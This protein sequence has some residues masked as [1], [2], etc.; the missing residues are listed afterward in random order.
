MRLCL[1]GEGVLAHTQL[2][3]LR[4]LSPPKTHSGEI[5]VPLASHAQAELVPSL[6]ELG[7]LTQLSNTPT[8]HEVTQE[9]A[10]ALP[11]T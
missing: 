1:W 7:P 3:P 4:N 9:E 6:A 8:L 10:V 11:I 5:L 2:S